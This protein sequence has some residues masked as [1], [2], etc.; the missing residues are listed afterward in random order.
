MEKAADS[1]GCIWIHSS[2]L[3]SRVDLGVW[4]CWGSVWTRCTQRDFPAEMVLIFHDSVIW[5]YKDC[6]PL[7]ITVEVIHEEQ[8][9]NVV[10][11]R[12]PWV[13]PGPSSAFT[14][15]LSRFQ[16]LPSTSTSFLKNSSNFGA[17]MC[18]PSSSCS[19]FQWIQ[20]LPEWGPVDKATPDN[21]TPKTVESCLKI[22]LSIP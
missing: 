4:L 17:L 10:I 15:P 5:E 6:P 18:P 13:T 19:F 9:G 21:T 7:S 12:E 14:V 3:G 2:R 22:H 1:K 20:E 8:T 16:S 11:P